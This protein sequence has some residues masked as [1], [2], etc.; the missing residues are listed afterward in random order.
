[1]LL[2]MSRK[3][4]AHSAETSTKMHSDT[5]AVMTVIS[6]GSRRDGS[7]VSELAALPED[8]GSIPSTQ[9]ENSNHL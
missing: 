8:E 5:Q 9:M 1:M 6:C 4:E 3:D 2:N 7:V